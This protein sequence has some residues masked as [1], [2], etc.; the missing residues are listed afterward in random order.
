MTNTLY[1]IA[2]VSAYVKEGTALDQDALKRGTSVYLADRVIPMLPHK[3]SNGI[4]S[5][6]PNE[7]RLVLA[8]LMTISKEGKLLNYDICEGVIHS[9]YRMTYAKV[10]Q[11]L[12][13][14]PKA[15]QEFPDLIEP[16]NTMQEL[17]SILQRKR[18]K[19]GALEFDIKEYK[20]HLNQ[21]R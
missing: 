4:C 14:N 15:L 17:A 8:C 18:R 13:K 12:E 11:I 3:L 5:L 7:D 20:F 19:M 6:N 1:Y 9:K 10:N 16:L 21:L 2:D